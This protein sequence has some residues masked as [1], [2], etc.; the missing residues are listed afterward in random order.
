MQHEVKLFIGGYEV[1]FSQDPKILLNYKQTEML[2]PTVVR[3]AYTKT[4]TLPGTNNNNNIFQQIWRLDRY[5]GNLEFNPILKTDFLLFVDG[6]LFQKG[7][8]KLDKVES[9]N[10][11]TTYSVTLY[12]GLGQFLYNL[13]YLEGSNTKRTLANLTYS[14]EWK[15]EPD[16][17]FNITK[18]AVDEAWGQLT[19]RYLNWQDRWNV[20]N[21]APCYNGI[22]NDFTSDKVLINHNEMPQGIFQTSVTDGGKT[23]MPLING[24]FSSSGYSIGEASQEMTEWETMDLRS[25][26]QRPV[27]SMN[28]FIE[29]VCRPENNGGYEVKLDSHFFNSDNPYYTDSWVTLNMLTDLDG[30]GGE[31]TEI[32]GATI[33]PMEGTYDGAEWFSVV[34]DTTSLAKINNVEFTVNVGVNYSGGNHTQYIYTDRHVTV[35]NPGHSI[36]NGKKYDSNMGVIIQL[37]G[38][39]RSGQAVAQSKAYLLASSKNMVNSNDPLWRDFWKKG[40]TGSEPE[41]EYVEGYWERI[42]NTDQY[43]FCSNS[44][45]YNIKFSFPNTTEEITTLVF[46]MKMPQDYCLKFAGNRADEKRTN[47]NNI[48]LALYDGE[49]IT[50]QGPVSLHDIVN[51]GITLAYP[52]FNV[53]DFQAVI[54]DYERMFSGT[55]ITKERLLTGDFTPA[56]YLLSYCKLFGL[57]FYYDA[58]EESEWPD[59]YPAGVVH[60]MDRDSFYDTSDVINLAERIDY[61]KKLTITPT[62]AKSKWYDFKVEHIE[63]E[64]ENIYK[65]KYGQEYGQQVIDTS[66]NFN[67]DT[68]ELYDGN[69]FKSGIMAQEKDKYFKKPDPVNN[70]VFNGFTQYLYA[71]GSGNDG[72]DTYENDIQVKT[73]DWWPNL[74]EGNIE[75]YDAF[76]KLVCHTEDNSSSDGQNVLLF[77]SEIPHEVT[78]FNYWLTDDIADMIYLNDGE[79]CWLLTKDEYDIA[80]K[81]I[82]IALNELPN[83]TRQLTVQ[84]PY[85]GSF[86]HTWDFGHPKATF[87]PDTFT[88]E[89]DSIYDK[90]WKNYIADLYDQNTRKL[91][92]YVRAEFDG[93]P[94]PYWFRRFYWFENSIWVLNE[95]SDLN[96]G[97]NDVVKME[98]IKVQDR[99]D[100]KLK[101][102]RAAGAFELELSQ[103][104]IG[105]D[106]T[107]VAGMIHNAGG[108]GWF[109]P[110]D[111]VKAVGDNGQTYYFPVDDIYSPVRGHGTYS[112]FRINIPRNDKGTALNWQ[113]EVEDDQDRKYTEVLRQLS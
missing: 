90:C 99:A 31:T 73:T 9:S 47:D 81:K 88:I 74:N 77:L 83:F 13:T 92:C 106:A 103:Y 17:S 34:A 63:S 93:K 39:N 96:V 50:M 82:A 7:Y 23:Y 61:S 94:W 32:S 65:E 46:K 112:T 10:N 41:Y 87:V 37:F 11:Y 12:G 67:S 33:V 55:R 111:W 43:K 86:A 85:T 109:G 104:E 14:T 49:Y 8:V 78:G 76:P 56:D 27:L 51:Q 6:E 3:N 36:L 29:A 64:V 42:G 89:T 30:T 2:N 44:Y 15:Q 5:Q 102:I 80:G 38:Y 69:V 26:L 75:N 79:P 108:G 84:H 52:Y 22:P 101:K 113:I 91:T 19:N 53:L 45:Q 16:F 107:Q 18:E 54:T 20:I 95:I 66:Y 60:I 40:D 105:P 59:K 68:T 35:K 28:R 62:L 98:F 4:L 25:Y 72:Y 48:Q 70:Y 97:S 71:R 57:Y 24:N 58:T 1:E 21:F 110:T 100:Y